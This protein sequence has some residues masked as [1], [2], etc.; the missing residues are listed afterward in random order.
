MTSRVRSSG[1]GV[2]LGPGG[3]ERKRVPPG[4]WGGFGG[5]EG[6]WGD[7][8]IPPTLICPPP[9]QATLG[10]YITPPSL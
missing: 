10:L 6:V 7:I 2:W 1:V 8:A 3:P 5:P 4:E 9:L